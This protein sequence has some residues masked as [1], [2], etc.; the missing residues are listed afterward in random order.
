MT[1]TISK[2]EILNE[3]EKRSSFEGTAFPERFEG[4]WVSQDEGE[5]LE[6]YWIEAYTGIVRLLKRY[7]GS[8]TVAF[9]LN[10]YDKEEVI[11]LTV[12]TP[13][14][15]NSLF[16]G[17][18]ATDLKMLVACNMLVGWLSVK[19]P[20]TVVKYEK[21]I[22]G[23]SEDLMTKLLYRVDPKANVILPSDKYMKADVPMNPVWECLCTKGCDD[24]PLVQSRPCSTNVKKYR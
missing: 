16:D 15:Y 21:E 7:L 10:T 23:Y 13:K 12:E 9:N 2:Q 20:D 18:V 1:I 11:E 17:S 8:D 22:E 6:S 3:I 14:R 5:L 19:A 24:V 4:V